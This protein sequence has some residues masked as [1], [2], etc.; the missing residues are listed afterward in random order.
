[1]GRIV[2]YLMKKWRHWLNVES[3]GISKGT[4][5]TMLWWQEANM[6]NG[7]ILEWLLKDIYFYRNMA[8]VFLSVQ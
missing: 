7:K 4:L 8:H 2:V 6:P 3:G 1:M 5:F